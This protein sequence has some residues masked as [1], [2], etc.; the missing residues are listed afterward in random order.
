[1]V[2]SARGTAASI[3]KDTITTAFHA[4][5]DIMPAVEKTQPSYMTTNTAPATLMI[6]FASRRSLTHFRTV[7]PEKIGEINPIATPSAPRPSTRAE[8]RRT[9]RPAWPPVLIGAR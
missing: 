2:A 3:E 9:S 4:M 6:A 7:D 8:G 1:V 5:N